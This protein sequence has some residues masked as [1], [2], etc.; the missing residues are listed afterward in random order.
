MKDFAEYVWVVFLGF[1]RDR[2]AAAGRCAGRMVAFGELSR[3]HGVKIST[4]FSVSVEECSLAVAEVVGHSSVRSAARMNGAVVIFVD[5]VAKANKVVE[6]GIVVKDSFVSVAPLTAPAARVTI[7][8][9]PPFIGDEA[10][11]REL[12]RH[13]KIVSAIRKLPSGCKSPLLRHVVSHRRQVHMILNNKDCDL[14]LVFKFKVDDFEYAVFVNSGTLKCFACGKEGHL[15]RACPEKVPEKRAEPADVTAGS[16]KDADAVEQGVAGVDKP[17]QS[18]TNSESTKENAETGKQCGVNPETATQRVVGNVENV[19]NE[20]QVVNHPENKNVCIESVAKESQSESVVQEEGNNTITAP[21]EAVEAGPISA[22]AEL[23]DGEDG[24]MGEEESLK[25]PHLKRKQAS[26]KC[27]SKA[28]KQL[29]VR[30]RR[31]RRSSVMM[32][33]QSPVGRRRWRRV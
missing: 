16:S 9:I 29:L 1:F 7:S 19:E 6:S 10:L 30:S 31:S 17:T 20:M 12:S 32:R 4:S 33:R 13:G 5:S 18:A 27:G 3:K 22:A 24:V 21:V 2:P 8:N 15:A 14:S 25:A 23:S 26:E 28:K 11:A